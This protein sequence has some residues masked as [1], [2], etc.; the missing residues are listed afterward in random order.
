MC[1]LPFAHLHCHSHYSLLDGAGTIRGLLER[2]KALEMNA[3]A[4]TDHGNLHGSLQFYQK[5]KDLGINPILGLEA[6]IAPGSRFHKESSGGGTKEA[7]YHITLL[8]R[9]HAGFQ[10]LIQLSSAAFL[11]GFYFKPRID[12]ELLAAHR[13]GLICLSG[14]V[15]SELNRTILAGGEANMQKAAEIAA[16]FHKLFGNDYYIELQNNNLEVQ[17]V[18]MEGSIDIANRL[19]LPMVATSDVHYINRDDAEAQDILLCVNTGKFRTDTKRMRMDS[20]EFYLRGPEEMYAAFP[21][22]EEALK[23]TQEIADSVNIEL[24]LGKRHFPVYTLPENKTAEELLLELCLTGLKQRYANRPDRYA[25]GKLSDEVMARLDRELGV[26]N[27]LGFANYFLIVWDYVHAARERGIQATARGSGVGALVSYGLYLSHVCPLEYDLL[28]ERFLDENRREAPDIDIDLCQQRR[29]EVIQYVKEKYGYENVAQIGTFGTMAARAAIRDVGRALGLP[30][31][32]VD[33]IVAMVPEELHITLKQAIEKSDELKKTYDGD[34]EVRKLLDLAMGIEGLARNVGTHAAA[35]VIAD[36]PL[37]D[38]VPLQHVQDKKEVIT[39]WAMGDVERAG[40]LKMDFLGLRNLTILSKVVDLI[41]QTTGQ[42]IDPYEFPRDDK[43]TFALLCRGE[44]KGVFQLESGGIRDLLQRMKPD[45]FLD[46]IATNALY[47]PG[48]LEGGMVDDYIEV[49]HGRKQPEYKHPVMKEI[50]EETNGVMVYQ[51]QVMRILN[52]LGGIKLANAYSCIKAISKKKLDMIAKYREEFIEG[53]HSQGLSKKEGEELFGL[54]EK[55]AGYGFNKCVV[56]ETVI[57]DADSGDRTTVEDLFRNRRAFRIHALGD[58]GKLRPQRV[59]DV[60]W[61]GRKKVFALTTSTGKRITATSNHP[62]STLN[63]WKDLGELQ[64]GDRIAAPRRLKIS[65]GRRW[66]RHEIIALA[67]LLSEGNTCHPTCLYFYN[68]DLSLID[69]FAAVA[70]KFPDSSAKITRRGD[71]RRMEVCVSTG[72]DRRFQPGQTPWNSSAATAVATPPIRSGMY[73]WAKSLDL[74]GKKATAKAVP[75]VV[76]SLRDKDLELFLGRLWAGDGFLGGEKQMPFYATSSEQL[77]RDVQTLLMRLGIVSRVRGTW[78]KRKC[79]NK[80]TKHRGYTVHLLGGESVQTFLTRI[81]PHA[82]GREEQANRLRQSIA[83]VAPDRT[84]KDTIPA[85]IRSWVDAEREKAG[86]TWRQLE[87]QSSICMR[88]FAGRGTRQKRGFRRSTIRKLAVFF[89]SRQ[90]LQA[91]QS[92]IFWETVLRIEPQGIQDTY[93]LTV[94]QDHNFIADGLVVHNS[95]STAYALV[96]YMTAYLK[97]HYPVEFMA[98]LLSSDITGRNFKRKDS[99]VE[100]IEDCQRMNVTVLPPDVNR[101]SAEFTVIDGKICFG[102]SAIKGCGGA[103]ATALAAEREAHGPFRSLFDF[104]ERLDPGAVN[105]TAI[106]SLIKAGAFDSLGGHRAQLFAAIDR[107][108]QAGAAAATDRRSGQK[109]LFGEEEEQEQAETG[110]THLPDVPR[111]EDREQL[112]KE[113]EVLGYYLTSHPLAE[114]EKTLTTYCS[115]TTV[116]AAAQKH[117]TEVMLGGMI[118]ALKLAHTKNPKPGS[119][120]RYAMFDLEDTEGIMRCIVWPEQFAHYEEFIKPDAIVAI[121]GAVDKRPGSEEA[122]LIVN[123]LMT[124]E[125]LCRRGTRGVKIRLFEENDGPQ[126]LELLHEILR[127]YPGGGDLELTFC[128]IDGTRVPCRCDRMKLDANNGE[129]RARVEQLLGPGNF[130]LITAAPNGG[131]RG[132][133]SV[134]SRK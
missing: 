2:A 40:L 123:E 13:E 127:G 34:P 83:A 59:E 114:H 33:A 36:R 37:T 44:T 109:S 75:P 41:E 94:E 134:V 102:L 73:R 3:L 91:A 97:A 132:R 14:C 32:R 116:D 74:L 93:D 111:W 66:Q 95:H 88:E 60:V 71:S 92:D 56:G 58:N 50:L 39:Q 104:C 82:L 24:E 38:Y 72:A 108:L 98:A 28:F 11:E 89:R 42:R 133:S 49:K 45:H 9:N 54:I 61:N 126:K 5:A 62:F 21:G 69:E 48:P 57:V 65:Q 101:S 68:N 80:I 35:V 107:A 131:A 7:A 27:K 119:P 84:S 46:I 51:E 85:E 125:D 86:L 100:H 67:Y 52:R 124:L 22:M 115:H 26:I 96:A 112:A 43:E 117:R 47:R 106:E 118:S 79:Q 103:A 29:G 4:L 10:N 121:R 78:F 16:W 31:P 105:R 6:Y 128:L 15:S 12:K 90:L 19:G 130:R 1:A 76:F 63:G 87:E 110:S 120:S 53:A 23:R 122:N 64:P 20:N 25:D 17:R 77:A 70:R 99:L 30:I 55:F 129:M 18:A 81:V 8:A 113:K